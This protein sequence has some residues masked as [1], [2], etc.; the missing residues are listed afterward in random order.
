M[1]E[2]N[3]N[4]K[5]QV[6]M[7]IKTFLCMSLYLI[8]TFGALFMVAYLTGVFEREP[9]AQVLAPKVYPNEPYYYVFPELKSLSYLKIFEYPEYI[10]KPLEKT[11]LVDITLWLA[12]LGGIGMFFLCMPLSTLGI[13]TLAKMATIKKLLVN[14]LWTWLSYQQKMDIYVEVGKDLARKNRILKVSYQRKVEEYEHWK[15]I[16]DREKLQAAFEQEMSETILI[17]GVVFLIVL[18]TVWLIE[19]YVELRREKR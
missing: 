11:L 19:K 4:S 18:T 12:F 8:V 15:G 16:I 17:G 13:G 10:R 7:G 2:E 3:R 14:P 6:L 5:Q 9:L 1:E